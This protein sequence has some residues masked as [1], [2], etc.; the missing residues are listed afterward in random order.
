VIIK[1]G[2]ESTDQATH[3]R[4]LMNKRVGRINNQRVRVY[5]NYNRPLPLESITLVDDTSLAKIIKV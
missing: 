2:A 5:A 4:A 1:H 3:L